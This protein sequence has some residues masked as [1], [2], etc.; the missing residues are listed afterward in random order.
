MKFNNIQAILFDVDGTLLD[1]TELIFRCYEYTIAEYS[2]SPKTREKISITSGEPLEV[3][4]RQLFPN[5]DITKLS[6]T[7]M[8]FQEKN[9][10]LS[11]PFNKVRQTLKEL[12]NI[13]IKIAAV[14]TRSKRTSTKS[15]EINDIA[16]L[17]DVVISRE[18]IVNPKPHP[19]ALIAALNYLKVNPK[20]AV[21]V[22]DT[23]IDIKAGKNAKVR[24]IGV[25]YG[26]LGDAVK[27]A[28]PDMVISDISEIISLIKC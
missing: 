23:P 21:M 4:Y 3:C 7:H 6:E 13:G 12:N 16:S 10:H 19:D 24:T 8:S 2:L 14:T 15:L 1:T 22:G 17:M 9:L 18:E 28:N 20:N 26:P 11:K 25:T 5:E 27:A